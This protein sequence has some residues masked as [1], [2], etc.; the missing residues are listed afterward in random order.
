[1]RLRLCTDHTLKGAMTSFGIC[2]QLFTTI[3]RLTCRVHTYFSHNKQYVISEVRLL[4]KR[5]LKVRHNTAYLVQYIKL[6]ERQLCIAPI[7]VTCGAQTAF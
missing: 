5:T 1:M 2:T 7:E 6:R 4:S 3:D